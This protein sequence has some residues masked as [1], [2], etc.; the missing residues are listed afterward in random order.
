MRDSRIRLGLPF[1][2]TLVAP[3][4]RIPLTILKTAGDYVSDGTPRVHT[5]ASRR[6]P[7]RHDQRQVKV[8]FWFRICSVCALID[9][10]YLVNLDNIFRGFR[11]FTA[12]AFGALYT[13]RLSADPD[14]SSSTS[15]NAADKDHLQTCCPPLLPPDPPACRY[16]QHH[17]FARIC[18][19][20]YY[21]LP[22]TTCRLRSGP[23]L[24]HL[25]AASC[26]CTPGLAIHDSAVKVY[27]MKSM[28]WLP[29]IW[30]LDRICATINNCALGDP[31]VGG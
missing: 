26:A 27:A 3:K 23:V 12:G 8:C 6:R 4:C 19:G 28:R 1:H 20:S 17:L 29:R 24:S 2:H 11:F 31:S 18:A 25:A 13:P 22:N 9:Y 14:T 16:S 15:A 10:E 7:W 5:S 30:Y 21:I